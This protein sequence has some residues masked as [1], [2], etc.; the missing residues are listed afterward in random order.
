M[1]TF[2][3]KHSMT[4]QELTDDF[5]KIV[6]NCAEYIVYSGHRECVEVDVLKILTPSDYV[7]AFGKSSVS[8]LD[9]LRMIK[10]V[11]KQTA[12]M[13]CKMYVVEIEPYD[14]YMKY[15]RINRSK[16]SYNC[17]DRSMLTRESKDLAKRLMQ[18]IKL[19]TSGD[20]VGNIIG[21]E[22]AIARTKREIQYAKLFNV[23]KDNVS[24]YFANDVDIEIPLDPNDSEMIF[25]VN[26]NIKENDYRIEGSPKLTKEQVDK[27]LEVI[28]N[29]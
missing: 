25:K 18:K 2:V 10:D 23:H 12:K 13:K 14:S 21:A 19:T 17:P 7:T 29:K 15:I 4:F 8:N 22:K 9:T 24:S 1:K 16:E 5:N 20:V 27:I 26:H 6:P 28:K 11:A 3:K